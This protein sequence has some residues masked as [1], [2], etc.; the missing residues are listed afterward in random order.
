MGERED[1]CQKRGWGW[2]SGGE[3]RACVNTWESDSGG[4]RRCRN[5]E[6]Q[7]AREGG[8]WSLAR[9]MRRTI[10]AATLSPPM[11]EASNCEAALKSRPRKRPACILPPRRRTHAPAAPLS[12]TSCARVPPT[13]LIAS[14]STFSVLAAAKSSAATAASLRWATSRSR[15]AVS[16]SRAREVARSCTPAL[17]GP[18]EGG[19]DLRARGKAEF[20]QR[21]EARGCVVR[22]RTPAPTARHCEQLAARVPPCRSP[23]HRQNKP[24]TTSASS[25]ARSL[26]QPT[27]S[28]AAAAAAAAHL[29]IVGA[30]TSPPLPTTGAGIPPASSPLPPSGVPRTLMA[31]RPTCAAAAARG[32]GGGCTV[33]AADTAC[34]SA[35]GR[36]AAPAAC[37]ASLHTLTPRQRRRRQVE[38]D[39]CAA[40]PSPG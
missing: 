17:P 24:S 26:H 25:Q 23:P 2:E 31:M 27:A 15:A 36:T 8:G 40:P 39:G 4:E 6:Q 38:A 21:L 18:C 11:A 20:N 9:S 37:D 5:S 3:Q 32:Q 19:A 28:S 10:K 29:L 13:S 7:E 30:I 22:L 14:W 34:Q 33:D 35:G 16:G 12:A 1:G